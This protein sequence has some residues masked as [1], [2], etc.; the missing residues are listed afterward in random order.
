MSASENTWAVVLAAGDGTRLSA[1]TINSR[2]EF[3]PKQYCS[4]DGQGSLLQQALERA[5]RV[6]APERVCV[7]VAEQHRRHWRNS[8]WPL[9]LGNVIVQ[10]SNRGTANG[11]LLGTLKILN[12]DRLARIVF[13]PAD[14][15][16]SDEPKLA[17]AIADAVRSAAVDAATLALVGI[18]PDDPDPELGYIL[19]GRTLPDGSRAVEKF[20]EKPHPARARGL[21]KAGALWNSFI[22]AAA[23]SALLDSLR[24]RT[25]WIVRGMTAA[26]ARDAVASCCATGLRE[27]YE[28]LPLVDFSRSIL[29]PAAASLRVFSAPCCGWSDLGTPKRVARTLRRLRTG[30]LSVPAPDLPPVGFVAASGIINLTTA[31]RVWHPSPGAVP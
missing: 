27:F 30:Y 8:P 5:R 1:L 21:I 10:P 14:H 15:H 12:R 31:Q 16:V 4:L 24:V 17:V 2:G 9:P 7:I 11:V 26:L 13:L 20:V 3:I 23:G 6:A 18:E 19:P 28:P 22:F 25:S 29:Q